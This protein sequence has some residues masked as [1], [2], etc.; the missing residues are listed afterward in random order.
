MDYYEIFSVISLP[1]GILIL[2]ILL[3]RSL[4]LWY[5]KIP[6]MIERQDDLIRELKNQNQLL[7]KAFNLSETVKSPVQNDKLASDSSEEKPSFTELRY[8]RS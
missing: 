3:C 2:L 5:F 8:G 1:L 6:D 4:I 7:K